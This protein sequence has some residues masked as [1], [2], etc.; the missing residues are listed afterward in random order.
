MYRARTRL[1]AVRRSSGPGLDRLVGGLLGRDALAHTAG[2]PGQGPVIGA[3][4]PLD[5]RLQCLDPVGRGL[6]CAWASA[7]DSARAA[8]GSPASRDDRPPARP[9]GAGG[10]VRRASGAALVSRV[11]YVGGAW[12]AGD[13]TAARAA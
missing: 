10:H 3:Q 1:L 8:T 2:E 13:L 4:R 6:A 12:A 7:A 5:H 11:S 9:V